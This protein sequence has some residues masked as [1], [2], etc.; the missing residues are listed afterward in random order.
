MFAAP[1]AAGRS[2]AALH[3]VENKEY[4][5]FV[6]NFS[7]LLQ[8]FTAEMIIAAFALDR[9]DDDGANVDLALLD[10]FVDLA[11]RGRFA[12]NHVGFTLRFR[13][14]KIDART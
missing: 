6:A 3:F 5:V 12:P 10:E 2:H 4:L 13:Q 8:P 1:I 9:L 7:Q 11:L 14:R